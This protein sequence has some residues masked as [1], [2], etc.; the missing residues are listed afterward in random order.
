M[1]FTGYCVHHDCIYVLDIIV[2]Y[3]G[4]IRLKLAI[5]PLRNSRVNFYM[6]VTSPCNASITVDVVNKIVL[7]YIY[8]YKCATCS[9]CIKFTSYIERI[10]Y[11]Q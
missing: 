4:Y 3:A 8:V 2:H 1:F 10:K 7:S 11:T 6:I 5:E 9:S